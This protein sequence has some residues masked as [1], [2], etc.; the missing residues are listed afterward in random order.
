MK[1]SVVECIGYPFSSSI[2]T[3][4]YEKTAGVPILSH[5]TIKNGESKGF[6]LGKR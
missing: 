3:E 1:E 6:T 4:K 5:K 2:T